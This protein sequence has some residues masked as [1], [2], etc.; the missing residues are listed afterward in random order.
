M[1]RVLLGVV[2]E[3]DRHVH[4]VVGAGREILDGGVVAIGEHREA[5]APRGVGAAREVVEERVER[6]GDGGPLGRGRGVAVGVR[7]VL[8]HAP[9]AIEDE[10]HVDGD[11]RGL[12]G[13]AGAA[14]AQ[15]PARAAF[16]GG[17]L[18]VRIPPASI[19][20]GKLDAVS[21][22]SL[23]HPPV[24]TAAPPSA[25]TPTA[26]AFFSTRASPERSRRRNLWRLFRYS[27]QA[28]A[29]REN[30]LGRDRSGPPPAQ[31]RTSCMRPGVTALLA[32]IWPPRVLGLVSTPDTPHGKASRSHARLGAQ[33]NL[34]HLPRARDQPLRPRVEAINALEDRIAKL[35]R[36]RA[37]GQDG[38]VQ[39]EARQR[40][41]RS[42]TSSSR[43]SPSAARRG[44]RALK[45]RHYDVQLI[46]GMVLHEGCIAEMRTGEGKTLVATL[47]CYLNALEGKGVHVVTVND[48]LARR[49][50][51]WMG[52]LYNFLGHDASAPSS[53]RRATTRRSARTASDITYGQNN[54]FGFD[55]L[56][57]NMKFCAL[58]YAQRDAPLRHRR[59]GR[60]DPHRRGAHAAHHQR[61]GRAVERTSTGRST[62]SS[63]ACARTSTTSSTRRRTRSPSPTRASSSPQKL[64]GIWRTSTT[65]STSRRCTSST[66]ACARTRSTSAT[67]TTSSPTTA[68]SSSST[69]SPAAC[70]PGGAGR[71]ACTRRS[72]R[73]RT[74]AS[75]KRPARWRRSPSRTSSAST[76]SSPA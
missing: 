35:S 48:Y 36:R 33:E 22:S 73:R 56:R 16:E 17:G 63:R 54:E 4:L 21:P 45:M 71:T 49:D 10:E 38:R 68:R 44:K 59:R 66:S 12:R 43:P 32:L 27:S 11:A 64:M 57:D 9:G 19:T 23:P 60:L 41:H 1:E 74:C 29:K 61:P 46:G 52:K 39:A 18:D 47:P 28:R 30:E 25:K 58:D 7:R 31:P 8:P 15:K 5:D 53:T 76:R 51:E 24:A 34:R 69:S 3:G 13:R 67:S 70:S 75:R 6:A 55:Y 72:R 2:D 20:R 42:T 26:R 50:A 37:Q 40:R 14:G 65:R 62:R